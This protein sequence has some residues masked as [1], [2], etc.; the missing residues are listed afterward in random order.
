[1]RTLLTSASLALALAISPNVLAQDFTGLDSFTGGLYDIDTTTNNA[2]NL[3]NVTGGPRFGFGLIDRGPDG[4]LYATGPGLITGYGI[5]S[6]DETTLTANLLY[7][8]AS[9]TAGNV[10]IAVHPSGN[11]I[12]V[13]GFVGLSLRVEIDEIDLATGTPV[14]RGGPGGNM[15]GLAFD[16]AGNLYGSI[17]GT[18]D[19][20]LIL[21]DQ[22][23]ASNTTNIGPMTGVDMSMGLDLA[24][25]VNAGTIH[26][27]SRASGSLYAIDTTSGAATLV[28]NVTGA[29]S[30]RSI[31]EAG[32]Q[33]VVPY[34]SG[35]AGS[36]GRTPE[37]AVRGCPEAGGSLSL[38]VSQG[39][40]LTNAVVFFGLGQGNIPIGGGC[41]ILAVPVLPVTLP[42][43]L[44]MSGSGSLPVALPTSLP[45]GTFTL[46]ALVA[47]QGSTNGFTLTGGVEITFP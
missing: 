4:T 24:S 12:W 47:D 25:E 46:Q 43:A 33:L 35:C 23:N 15:W 18:T 17:Q 40:P 10:G 29:G 6:I 31:A 42:L 37:L 30:V 2:T 19:P 9:S 36:N 20:E 5:Y 13:A 26:A 16:G 11:S 7:Q 41:S 3:G 38:E 14:Q 34:G 45:M 27:F 1:M 39:P 21:I 22:V 8:I 32:C 44:D 28:S